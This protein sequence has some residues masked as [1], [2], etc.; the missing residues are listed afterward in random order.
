MAV[1]HLALLHYNSSSDYFDCISKMGRRFNAQKIGPSLGV[2]LQFLDFEL[3]NIDVLVI[4]FFCILT[5]WLFVR[6]FENHQAYV[7]YSPS[8][9]RGYL[10]FF[11]FMINRFLIAP[12]YYFIVCLIFSYTLVDMFG[13]WGPFC[14][15]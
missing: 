15:L 11:M 3:V 5:G 12:N 14:W 9:L 7:K 1:A 10:T 6:L 4:L 13:I 2:F 8:K